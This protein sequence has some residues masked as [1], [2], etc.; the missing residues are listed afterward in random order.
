MLRPYNK[1]YLSC[2]FRGE[3]LSLMSLSRFFQ[4]ALDKKI[5]L[6]FIVTLF[7]SPDEELFK[8]SN[9]CLVMVDAMF[10]CLNLFRYMMAVIPVFP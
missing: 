9:A 3:V 7:D 4:S 5:C 2:F 10:I 1:R 8:S 6:Y